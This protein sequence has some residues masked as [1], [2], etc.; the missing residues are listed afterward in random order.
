M[1]ENIADYTRNST[2]LK[3]CLV[4]RQR[5]RRRHRHLLQFM[6]LS[7][8][9]SFLLL[10][11]SLS[12]PPP[13]LLSPWQQPSQ[14]DGEE[15]KNTEKRE[16]EEKNYLNFT[17]KKK[18]LKTTFNWKWNDFSLLLNISFFF[19]LSRSHCW[20][21]AGSALGRASSSPVSVHDRATNDAPHKPIK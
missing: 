18:K 17:C 19:L 6:L 2:E 10:F 1:K 20:Q 14:I 12:T 21:R 4:A 9:S 3:N 15:A 16:E 8:E 5:L 7:R 13:L 11:T